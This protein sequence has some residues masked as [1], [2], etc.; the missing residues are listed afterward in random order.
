MKASMRD[1]ILGMARN[2][3]SASEIA[4][5]VKLPVQLVLAVINRH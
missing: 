1:Q 5:V 3:Y 2:G 4:Y